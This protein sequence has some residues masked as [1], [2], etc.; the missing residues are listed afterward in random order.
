MDKSH[1]HKL[2]GSLKELFRVGERMCN[3]SRENRIPPY[4]YHVACLLSVH[5]NSMATCADNLVKFGTT[6]STTEPTLGEG[7]RDTRGVCE[8]EGFSPCVG[9]ETEGGSWSFVINCSV[10]F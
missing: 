2:I 10:F 7:S 3:M 6:M 8:T 9:R 4:V 1:V 5:G